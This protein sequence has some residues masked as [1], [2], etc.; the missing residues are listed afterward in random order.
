MG[1]ML[2]LI[3]VVRVLAFVP[4]YHETMALKEAAPI[5]AAD[6]GCGVMAV[7]MPCFRHTNPEGGAMASV[8][9]QRGSAGAKTIAA[10]DAR[11]TVQQVKFPCLQHT[12]PR[13]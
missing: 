3:L 2:P 10:Q 6:R 11:C 5:A 7:K 4:L 12:G 13:S 1:G 8:S 9:L